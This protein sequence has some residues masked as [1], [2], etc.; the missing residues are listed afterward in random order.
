MNSITLK[1]LFAYIEAV[2]AFL[3]SI[4]A[5]GLFIHYLVVRPLRGFLRKEIA[6]PLNDM[7]S[8]FE[9]LDSKVIEH[10]RDPEA[11]EREDRKHAKGPRT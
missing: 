8:K 6:A 11:H 2:G 7:I 1:Q 10:M 9:H 4:T 3:G 5:I